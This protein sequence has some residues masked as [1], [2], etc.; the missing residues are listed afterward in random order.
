MRIGILTFHRG[1]NYGGFLQAWHL[2]EAIHRLGHEVSI[3]NYQN[4]IHLKSEKPPPLRP[5]V[6]AVKGSIWVWLKSRPFSKHVNSLASP[7]LFTDAAEVQWNRYD[8]IVVGSDVI[9]D[10]Q[11]PQFGHDPVYFGSHL[12]QFGTRFISYA[13]SAGTTPHTADLPDYV[14]SG[15][16]RFASI[17]VRDHNTAQIVETVTGSSPKIV[18]DPTWLGDDPLPDWNGIPKTPYILVYGLG[19]DAQRAAE[20]RKWAHTRSLAIIS[21][22][23]PGNWAD[24]TF[25]Q[26]DPWHWVCLFKHA[27]AVVTSTLHGS[28]YAIKYKR[29]MLFMDRPASSLKSRTAIE[30]AGM[31]DVVLSQYTR[32]DADFLEYCLASE[33]TPGVPIDWQQESLRL[34]ENDLA[35]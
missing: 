16:S 22:A 13:A 31:A 35:D 3:I 21:A 27:Q 32:L 33:E 11:A 4:P 5:T 30:R 25:R 15:L 18:A 7:P 14:C 23:T 1:P 26:L 10:F 29:P 24:R 17:N 34:L 6:S 28:H 12:A 8:T 19:L 2:R 20:L 9:W